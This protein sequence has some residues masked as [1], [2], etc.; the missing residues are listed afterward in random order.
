MLYSL[1]G[2]TLEFDAMHTYSATY[3]DFTIASPK[4]AERWIQRSDFL[5]VIINICNC[6]CCLITANQIRFR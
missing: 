2:E 3:K 1:M 6:L 4:K 5:H